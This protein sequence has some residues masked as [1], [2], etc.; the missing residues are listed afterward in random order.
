MPNS[1]KAS[2]AKAKNMRQIKYEIH[3]KNSKVDI[4]ESRRVDF[5]LSEAECECETEVAAHMPTQQADIHKRE[6]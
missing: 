6:M 3:K 4:E 5:N 1:L 2:R